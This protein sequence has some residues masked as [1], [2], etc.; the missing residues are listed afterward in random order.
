MLSDSTGRR[1]R[2][3]LARKTVFM[4]SGS[5]GHRV[6]KT[7]KTLV[8]EILK[9]TAW[10]RGPVCRS[11][12][13]LARKKLCKARRTVFLL[14][15]STGC[16]LDWQSSKVCQSFFPLARKKWRKARRTVF[17]LSDSTGRRVR[18]TLA[19]RTVFMLSGSTGHRVRKT[20]K[21][22]VFEILKA[23]AWIRTLCV[24]VICT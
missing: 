13:H 15:G 4:L 20:L 18:K 7:L 23:T 5:T 2:K 14:S 22:L 6:K 24:G 12:L 11:Y 21:T 9:A 17:L 19:R 1:V 16:G 10:I 8:F 3:T